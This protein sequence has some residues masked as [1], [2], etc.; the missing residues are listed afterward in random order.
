MNP[1]QSEKAQS[2]RALHQTSGAFVMPNPWDAGSARI[3]ASLGFK[4]LASSSF[5]SAVVLGRRDGGMSRDEVLAHARSLVEATE[6]PVAAD[7]E[8]GFADSPAG[9]AETIHLAAEVGLVGGSIEDAT[10]DASRPFYDFEEAVD[11]VSAAVEA[12]RALPFPFTL[13][14][15]SENFVRGNPNLDDTIRRLQAFEAAGADVLF[16]PGLPDLTAVKTVCAAVKKPVNFMN[17]LAGKSFPT[18]ALAAAGVRRISLGAS[19]HR[20]ALAG[21]LNAA[22][23]ISERGTFAYADTLPTSAQIY[24][25]LG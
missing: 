6:L 13:T 9:V 5:A 20:A 17:G 23:E 7:L 18:E 19:L 14:A 3:L 15:R 25:L 2:F 4:A 1:T 22:R 12:A 11:R 24:Q 10:G 16:A 8:D 21:L